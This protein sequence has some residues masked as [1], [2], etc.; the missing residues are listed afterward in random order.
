MLV[1]LIKRLSMRLV[2]LYV[3]NPMKVLEGKELNFSS[4]YEICRAESREGYE[5]CDSEYVFE[6]K[7]KETYDDILYGENIEIYGIVGNNGTG[8]STVMD[9]IRRHIYDCEN[10]VSEVEVAISIWEDEGKFISF[11]KSSRKEE[12]PIY[13]YDCFTKRRINFEDEENVKSTTSLVYYSD[14]IDEKYVYNNFDDSCIDK[15][16]FMDPKNISTSYYLYSDCVKLRRM[17][18]YFQEGVARELK[19][20]SDVS[21]GYKQ[22]QKL[23]N[24]P[25]FV[26]L[27]LELVDYRKLLRGG[28]TGMSAN[29]LSRIVRGVELRESDIIICLEEEYRYIRRLIRHVRDERILLEVIIQYNCIMDIIFILFENYRNEASDILMKINI[30]YDN[31]IN[32]LMIKEDLLSIFEVN[33][34]LLRTVGSLLPEFNEYISWK[35]VFC[36]YIISVANIKNVE[37]TNNKCMIQMGIRLNGSNSLD[38]I[39]YLYK[40]YS[41]YSYNNWMNFSWGMSSGEKSRLSLFSRFYDALKDRCKDDSLILMDELD[42]YMHPIWQQNIL[43]EFVDFLNVMFPKQRFQIIFTTHSPITL[44]DV[45]KDNILFLSSDLSKAKM[46]ETFAANIASLYYSAFTMKKGSIGA[47]GKDFIGRVTKAIN[48]I[49][50][51]DEDKRE[52][53]LSLFYD[54]TVEE[55]SVMDY[56]KEIERIKKVIGFIGEEIIRTKL[57]EKFE[58]CALLP[59]QKNSGMEEHL[60][61]LIRE[62]GRTELMNYFNKL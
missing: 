46:D 48:G 41:I 30:E 20:I 1:K 52:K 23:Y 22:I 35:S 43:K 45:R 15:K 37:I 53:F 33:S 40:T 51:R 7:K 5:K 9:Y 44:S 8:K 26:E 6:V 57:L 47:V 58:Q 14:I 32:E 39:I 36:E 29:H 56:E 11:F 62:Y 55:I 54:K 59:K 2:Y 19:F 3:E 60:E 17:K 50:Y 13:L 38:P 21:S 27:Q 31:R 16:I 4:Q 10:F 42:Y 49:D 34:F 18:S 25:D 12:Q 24:I 61:Q 28:T